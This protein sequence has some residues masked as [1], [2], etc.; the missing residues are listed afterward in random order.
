[1]T[2]P[3][4]VLPGM[5]VLVTRRTLRRTQL[6][7]PDADV[8]RLYLY[9]LAVL[10]ERHSISVHAVTLMP[11]HEHLI[12]TDREGRLP[13]FL[14]ELHR[15]VALGIKVL[16]GW[17]GAVWDHERPSVVWLRTPQAVIEKLAYVMANPVAAGLV[18]RAADWPGLSTLPPQL[19]R[20]EL[21]AARPAGYFDPTNPRWAA[22][23]VLRLV[24][25]HVDDMSDDEV[26]DA[27]DSRLVSLE[28]EASVVVRQKGWT[29][30]G[31][32]RCRKA[33]PYGR[34]RGFEPLRGR[35]PTF[36]VGS[37]QRRAFFE[38]VA[39]L[40]AFRVAYASA[41]ER[42]RAGVRDVV[43]PYGTWA[44]RVL[45]GVGIAAFA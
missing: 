38:A 21:R 42:W 22:E 29:V 15:L 35:N 13:D 18:R 10:A 16:R 24:M 5:T 45:H 4:S 43:F 19:G 36:A 33:S 26:R 27:V 14:R 3:R 25:P 11:T 28:R 1:M 20:A 40:R 12:V 31:V 44:M 6:L 41:L 39:T 7:R 17:E 8:E 9:C 23:C 30:L 32:V 37:G 34:A 2:M